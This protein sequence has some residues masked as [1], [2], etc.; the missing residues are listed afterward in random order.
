MACAS[1]IDRRTRSLSIFAVPWKPKFS[2]SLI[3]H[4]TLLTIPRATVFMPPIY[5]EPKSV[6]SKIFGDY[7]LSS[8]ASF[9]Y[10]LGEQKQSCCLYNLTESRFFEIEVSLVLNVE[11]RFARH[12]RLA[13]TF[14]ISSLKAR[15]YSKPF[16][17]H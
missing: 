4:S 7:V 3:V 17:P 11:R 12:L 8:P 10:K 14:L 6:S 5:H 9:L 2:K 16:P 15:V 13:S 1:G